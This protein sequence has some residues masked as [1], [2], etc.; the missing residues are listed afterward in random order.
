MERALAEGK[1]ARAKARI[2][3]ELARRLAATTSSPRPHS[4]PSPS[5]V[6]SLKTKLTKDLKTDFLKASLK[7]IHNT[8][9]A[10]PP[11]ELKGVSTKTEAIPGS[12]ASSGVNGV[13]SEG[14][15]SYLEENDRLPISKPLP[16]VSTRARFDKM[17]VVELKQALRSRGSVVGGSKSELIERLASISE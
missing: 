11:M 16:G 2:Q 15:P 3:A 17:T 6:A 10:P 14:S 7:T 8:A 4:P 1:E 13:T 9:T 12:I 5:S